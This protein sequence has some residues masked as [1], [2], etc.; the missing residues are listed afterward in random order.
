MHFHEHENLRKFGLNA[1]EIPC[2]QVCQ[3]MDLCY[4][5]QIKG[6]RRAISLIRKYIRQSLI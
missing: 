2:L 5:E 3:S 1:R 4:L 6:A